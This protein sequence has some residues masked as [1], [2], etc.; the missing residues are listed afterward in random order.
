VL[1][2]Q[3]TRDWVIYKEKKFVWLTVLE[4]RG[5]L[6]EGLL[7]ASPHGRK[8]KKD[9][10]RR[11]VGPEHKLTLLLEEI[12]SFWLGMVAHTCNPRYSGDRSQKECGSRPALAKS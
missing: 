6:G 4:V 9:H 7:A 1:L 8:W 10:A 12:H 5:L 11:G 2:F 3:N